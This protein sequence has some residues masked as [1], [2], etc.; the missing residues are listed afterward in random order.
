HDLL[1][2]RILEGNVID[3]RN[4]SRGVQPP[5]PAS[6]VPREVRK[7]PELSAARNFARLGVDRD[8]PPAGKRPDVGPALL[9]QGKIPPRDRLRPVA[10]DL[11]KRLPPL[12]PVT[13][14]I[15]CRYV[16][17]AFSPIDLGIG[18]GLMKLAHLIGSA[19]ISMERD[20]IRVLTDAGI[21]ELGYGAAPK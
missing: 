18:I 8:H 20:C 4:L 7:S 11:G 2:I 6:Y 13:Q 14:V 9:I 19:H 12:R 5:G 21:V 10:R 1:P 16:R 15:G 17:P 3:S